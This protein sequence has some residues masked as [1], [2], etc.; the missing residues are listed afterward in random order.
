MR[1]FDSHLGIQSN[2]AHLKFMHMSLSNKKYIHLKQAQLGI[3]IMVLQTRICMP[4]PKSCIKYLH[5]DSADTG[6]TIN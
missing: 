3:H 6:D 1:F 4:Y 5:V 2:F